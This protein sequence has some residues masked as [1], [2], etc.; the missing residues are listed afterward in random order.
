MEIKKISLLLFA[1]FILFSCENNENVIID[2][3]N[4]LIG[5]WVS[6][7]YDNEKTIFKRGNSLPKDASG[8][9]F[10][11][12]GAFIERTSGFCGTPPLSFFNVEGT[13]LLENPIINISK[14]SYPS[15]YAWRIV[16][17]TETELVV[18]RELTE[19]EKD[20]RKL[21]D[22]YDEIY[23]LAYS[24]TCTNS[25][26]WLISPFGSKACGGPQGYIPYSKNIDT[27]AFLNKIKVYSDA[28]KEYNIKWGV[29]SDCSIIPPP[30]GIEC[31]NG[32]VIVN[33]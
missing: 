27:V 26:D 33:Y 10:K 11:P 16:S 19:Q 29:I 32:F 3:D 8:I 18:K 2:A 9:S 14:Q 1:C 24:V 15:N 13:F 4:L 6:P 5:F 25:S 31:K 30:K 17:L 21:M 7:T 23:N 12:N 22:L 28:E 20:H